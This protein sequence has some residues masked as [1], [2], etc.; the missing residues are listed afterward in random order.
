MT[1]MKAEYKAVL[2][3]ALKAAKGRY[4]QDVVLGVQ[5]LSGRDLRGK[6]N[7]YGARYARSRRN[8]MSRLPDSYEIRIQTERLL[9]HGQGLADLVDEIAKIQ[10]AAGQRGLHKAVLTALSGRADFRLAL[11]TACQATRLTQFL[12]V[13]T[14]LAY[15]F[16]SLGEGLREGLSRSRS[17]MP[18]EV[19]RA[20]QAYMAADKGARNPEDMRLFLDWAQV[21][22]LEVTLSE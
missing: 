10:P 13:L 8:L 2:D 14:A 12:G 17:Y 19:V 5:A 22:V 6:A 11:S 7:R 9:F 16:G 21:A 20:L 18:A 1:S 4:Q 15:S 3:S